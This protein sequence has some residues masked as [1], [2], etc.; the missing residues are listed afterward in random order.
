MV[1]KIEAA[2]YRE[3]LEGRRAGRWF[4]RSLCACPEDTPGGRILTAHECSF[5]TL[6][7]FIMLLLL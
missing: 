7:L 1:H 3:R 5:G 6:S 4:A 2:N